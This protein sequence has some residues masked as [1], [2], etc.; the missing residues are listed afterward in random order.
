MK[1]KNFEDLEIWQEARAL[2]KIIRVYT[3]KESF[4]KD[5]K[6]CSQIN[7]SSGSVMDNKAEGFEIP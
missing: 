3:R 6:L 5:F 7:A 1:A 2:S 4:S